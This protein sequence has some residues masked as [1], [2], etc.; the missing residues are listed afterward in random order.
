MLVSRNSLSDRHPQSLFQNGQE[1][2]NQLAGKLALAGNA[3]AIE[4][5]QGYLDRSAELIQMNR[6]AIAI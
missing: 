2:V 5:L 1:T 6:N 3:R 4:Y